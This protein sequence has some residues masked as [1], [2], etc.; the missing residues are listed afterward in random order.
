MLAVLAAALLTPPAAAAFPDIGPLPTPAIEMF[1][2]DA[3]EQNIRSAL[4][5][6]TVG[7]AY[8]IY[9]NSQLKRAGG[10]GKAV[11][12]STDM[13][14]YRRVSML[15]MSKT[16]TAA[17]LMRTFEI[18]QARGQ[19]VGPGSPIAP[20]LPHDWAHGLDVHRIS[21]ADLLRHESGLRAWA[22]PGDDPDLYRNLRMTIA[23]SGWDG[24]YRVHNYC[25]CNF[26]LLRV[27]IP[28]LLHG[29]PSRFTDWDWWLSP[30]RETGRIHREFVR[31]QVLARAGL[32]VD[33]VPS[34]PLPYTRYYNFPNTSLY[35]P[36][37]PD[38]AYLRAGAGYWYMSVNE[39]GQF[40]WRLRAGLIV[41]P[42]SWETMRQH[43][44]GFAVLRDPVTASHG[45]E[46]Y[47][48]SGYFG[49]ENG[50]PGPDDDIGSAGAWMMFPHG[51]TAVF[52]HN[53]L[54]TN[55]GDPAMLVRRAFDDAFRVSLPGL[56]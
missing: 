38:D 43:A 4:D 36:P 50:W 54:G 15:S 35:L 7:Y 53:S 5:G 32:D 46:Y 42:G 1:D 55:L 40:L 14:P 9:Q 23:R 37:L 27:L 11:V 33:L 34:G 20:W 22:L 8:A 26:A 56:P 25:N 28:H 6:K 29:H 47:T 48:H 31:E 3:F 19:A 30:D 16:I 2:M 52:F 41:S 51:I 49:I 12:P 13:T 45:G 21:F 24:Q 17:A 18:L 44:L 10:A 39:L